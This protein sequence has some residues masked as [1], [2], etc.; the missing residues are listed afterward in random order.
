MARVRKQGV[1]SP[2]PKYLKVLKY[3][4]KRARQTYCSTQV[5]L[6]CCLNMCFY[7]SKSKNS[8]YL[9]L[10]GLCQRIMNGIN[11]LL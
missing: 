9:Q 5:L 11:V 7:Y 3:V 10:P 1:S 6:S 8:L 2:Y 4:N